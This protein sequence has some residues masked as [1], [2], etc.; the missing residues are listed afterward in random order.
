MAQGSGLAARCLRAATI[1]IGA[2]SLLAFIGYPRGLLPIM[3]R[4]WSLGAVLAWDSFLSVLF[5]AQHSIMIR[6]KVR[7]RLESVIRPEYY[8]AIYSIA[9]GIALL[10]AVVLWQPSAL[11][12]YRTGGPA[13]WIIR[14]L[15]ALA[16]TGFAWGMFSLRPFDPF[17][18]IPLNAALRGRRLPSPSFSVRGPY[19]W[20]RHPLYSLFI[21]IL[22][23]NPQPTV[24]VLFGSAIWT[25]WI[26]L[27]TILEE[28]DLV[29]DFGN[30]YRR[31]QRG[32]PMFFPWRGR[33][34]E[35]Q[36]DVEPDRQHADDECRRRAE[37]N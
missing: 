29:S 20:V 14:A 35:W 27:G 3:P 34:S 32:V 18:V 36:R 26:V 31:Y 15:F 19:R 6:R 10:L 5:F 4:G 11:V 37:G 1:G 30:A 12:A 16:M 28:R 24:D 13:P 33:L 9:S 8:M 21:A 23:L 2:I 22:W 7:A 25:L 17:G